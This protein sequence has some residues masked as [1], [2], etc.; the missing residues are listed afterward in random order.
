METN[1]VAQDQLHRMPCSGCSEHTI[2]LLSLH[3]LLTKCT[4][5]DASKGLRTYFCP[6]PYP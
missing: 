2:H 6:C 3:V 5:V 1:I 4:P